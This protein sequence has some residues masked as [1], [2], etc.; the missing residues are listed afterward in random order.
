[1]ETCSNIRKRLSAYQD[2]ELGSADKK[3]V[4]A[5]LRICEACRKA[6]DT[7]LQ[8]YRL[9]EGLP[10]IDPPPGLLRQIIG[11][12]TRQGKS[13]R[14]PYSQK[15]FRWIPV[16]AL[17]I[18]PAAIGLLMGALLGHV[19]TAGQFHPAPRSPASFSDQAL[20]LASI[21]VFDATPPGSLANAYLTLAVTNPEMSHEK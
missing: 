4:E 1:M 6:Y 2:Q 5:H 14:I 16:P 9:L 10:A 15:I 18:L 8:T 7:L 19:I 12:T 13:V 11:R 17:V 21:R 20:T 3:A